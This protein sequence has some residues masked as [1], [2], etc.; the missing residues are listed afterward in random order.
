[1]RHAA[2]DHL[3]LICKVVLREPLGVSQPALRWLP[4]E[5]EP[6]KCVRGLLSV[7]SVA[8]CNRRW[9]V[10][11]RYAQLATEERPYGASESS[12]ILAS[13]KSGVSKPS[14]NQP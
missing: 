14:V 2:K 3:G 12:K 11:F 6:K 9:L 10:D 1:M 4:W 13:L 7:T 5:P 8:F